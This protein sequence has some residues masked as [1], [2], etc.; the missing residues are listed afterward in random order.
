MNDEKNISRTSD[1]FEAK[2]AN[3]QAIVDKLESDPTVSLQDGMTLF[4]DGLKLTKECV[5]MLNATRERIA[6]LD[7]QL[8]AV[9]KNPLFGDRDE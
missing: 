3:L 2:I 9:L 4:E 7:K 8:E 1:D 5:D 6:D